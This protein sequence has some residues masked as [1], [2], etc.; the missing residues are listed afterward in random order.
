MSDT[1]FRVGNIFE[2]VRGDFSMI[3]TAINYDKHEVKLRVLTDGEH[4][5]KIVTRTIPELN[6]KV[7]NG[8]LV[9][10]QLIELEQKFSMEPFK[11]IKEK[12]KVMITNGCSYDEW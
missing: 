11:F 8:R 10:Y 6:W 3:I 4:K 9:V 7:I 2:L 5:N 12:K 1:I